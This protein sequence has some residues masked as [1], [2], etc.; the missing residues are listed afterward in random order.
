MLCIIFFG[1]DALCQSIQEDVWFLSDSLRQGRRFGD[2]GVVDAAFWVQHEFR[3]MGLQTD[4]QH[5]KSSGKAGHNVQGL[6][7]VPGSSK[8]II[9]MACIDGVGTYDGA[10]Y[11]GADANASGVASMMALA[12][13][14]TDHSK[15]A[16]YVYTSPRKLDKELSRFR[17]DVPLYRNG[18]LWGG[19][20]LPVE[21]YV[22]EEDD[23]PFILMPAPK[24]VEEEYV[25]GKWL[26]TGRPK[27]NVLFVALDGHNDHS[28][29]AACLWES[30]KAQGITKSDILMVVNLDT[31]GSNM[32][33]PQRYWKDYLIILGGGRYESAIASC[34]SGLGLHLYYDYYDSRSFTDMFYKR[35]GDQSVF[36]SQ[37]IPSVMVTSGITMLTNKPG[38]HPSTLSYDLLERRIELL[39]RW[40][41]KL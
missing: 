40:L 34:N 38:D 7:Q 30:L 24:K 36:V 17:L 22:E 33:P 21:E 14:M 26:G 37:G 27:H 15:P 11:P 10:L 12:R 9:V 32:A 19:E 39:R 2:P 13:S 5:F 20:V 25:P 28:S 31:M 35:L 6:L 41:L 18:L 8:Y 3:T 16:P 23:E 1:P 29:G 4:V